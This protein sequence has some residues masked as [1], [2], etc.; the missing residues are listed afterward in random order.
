MSLNE[1]VM[2]RIETD[3]FPKVD[4]MKQIKYWAVS[5]NSRPEVFC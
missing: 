2:G 5:G 3:F 4:L 1:V